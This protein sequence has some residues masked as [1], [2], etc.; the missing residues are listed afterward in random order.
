MHSNI[1]HLG[2]TTGSFRKKIGSAKLLSLALTLVVANLTVACGVVSQAGK[3]SS[4]NQAAGELVISVPTHAAKVGFGFTT[5]PSVSGGSAPYIFVPNGSLPPGITVNATTGSITGIPKVAGTYSFTL[6]VTDPPSN[7]HGSG[8]VHITVAAADSNTQKAAIAVS[9]STVTVASL[10]VQQFNASVSGTSSTAVTW[11]TTAGTVSISGKFAAPQVTSNT[12]VTITATSTADGSV[13]GTAA[14]VVTAPAQLAIVKSVLPEANAGM[15]YT[16]SLSASGGTSPYQWTLSAGSL[17]SGIQLQ[18]STGVINGMTSLSGSFAFT[19]KVTDSAGSSSTQAFTLPVSSNSA[20]GFDGPAELP[21]VYIQTAMANTP[22]SGTMITLKSG[23]DLQS[24]LNSANC[25]DTI[26]LQAGATFSGTFTFP[27]KSCDDNHWVIVRTNASDSALPAEGSRLTPCYAGVASLPGRPALHCVSTKNV[28]AKLTMTASGL[29]PIVFASGANHY[30]LLGLEITRAV[31]TGVVDSL[32]SI[33]TSGTA[34]NLILDRVWLHGT[35]QDETNKGLQLIGASYVSLIDSSVTDLHCIAIS[36]SCTD[37]AAIGGGTGNPVGPFKII[38]NFLEAAGENIIFGGAESATTPADIEIRHNH[39]FK[40]LTWLKGQPGYV[41]GSDGNPFIVKNLL[42]LK[43]AE[44]VLIEGNIMENSWGGFS[45][46]GFG[47]LLTPKNQAG[48]GTSNLCANCFVTDVTVRYN[49]ISHVGSGLQIGNE[50]S[51][52]NGG[53]L[54]GQRYSIHDL[55]VDDIDP[56]KYAGGGHLAEIVSLLGAPLLQNVSMNHITAFPPKGLFSIGDTTGTKIPNFTFNN[57]LVTVGIYPVWSIGGGTANC[58]YYDVPLTTF[59]ACFSPYS[60][61]N[62]ALIA[63]PS[64]YPPS[65][66]PAGNA[67]PSSTSTVQFLNYKNGNGGDYHLLSS[68]PYK[69]AGT[70]GK[71]LGADVDTVLSETVGVY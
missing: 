19:A 59:T 39:F 23:G 65:K 62:N 46:G 11:S 51:D 12:S 50:L 66:W 38:D 60:F 35:S 8:T 57:N 6:L 18:S 9:P 42:E 22:A 37:S 13:R 52:N 48:A 44:R 29:G 70:D 47:I 63:S 36:G 14:V 5:V 17:P 40:P 33:K 27:A 4:S 54:D 25:G 2:V 58:A 45:Q 67:F 61:L 31:G 69:N 64:S 55:I 32:A 56:V 49:T 28:L 24:A 41:G 53:A 30:R 34:N 1:Q 10:G 43:N 20:N 71:D 21:R 15:T 3:S 68:S 16:A 26:A 7:D